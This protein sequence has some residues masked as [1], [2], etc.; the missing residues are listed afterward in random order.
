MFAYC[1][2]LTSFR[3][4]LSSLEEGEAMFYECAD[5]QSFDGKSL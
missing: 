3:G 4:D 1:S 5:L 2:K